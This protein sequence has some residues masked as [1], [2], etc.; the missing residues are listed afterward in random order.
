MAPTRQDLFLSFSF[1]FRQYYLFLKVSLFFLR[2]PYLLA[3]RHG[4]YSRR[5][6]RPAALTILYS[7]RAPR[8][9]YPSYYSLAMDLLLYGAPA[10]PQCLPF[11]APPRPPQYSSALRS[12]RRCLAGVP[13]GRYGGHAWRRCLGLMV[14]GH[15]PARILLIQLIGEVRCSNAVQC[16]PRRILAV[17]IRVQFRRIIQKLCGMVASVFCS[18]FADISS[19]GTKRVVVLLLVFVSPKDPNAALLL[20]CF[21]LLQKASGAGCQFVTLPININVHEHLV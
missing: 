20:Q 19:K 18:T 11:P 10:P 15:G 4:S 5:A 7:R 13:I 8:R 12:A 16:A 17:H 1:Y 21:N 3:P 9:L 6:P 14:H 2:L